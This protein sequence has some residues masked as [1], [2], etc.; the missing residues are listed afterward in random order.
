MV[1]GA[2]S[3]NHISLG[4]VVSSPE[5]RAIASSTEQVV[6]FDDAIDTEEPPV[7]ITEQDI[8]QA[9]AHILAG[10]FYQIPENHLTT[11]IERLS[12]FMQYA[13]NQLAVDEAKNPSEK[14][15]QSSN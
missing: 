12:P 15:L 3:T 4:L 5:K 9:F 2:G 11:V 13:D 1:L 6:S 8:D 7:V 14:M 10:N